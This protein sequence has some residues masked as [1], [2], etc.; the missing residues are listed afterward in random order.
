FDDIIVVSFVDEGA[1][2]T[3]DP[4]L[5]RQAILA[6]AI[7]A[8]VFLGL[9]VVLR[10][11]V[12]WLR[13]AIATAMLPAL[14]FY[15]AH[16]AGIAHDEL[17]RTAMELTIAFLSIMGL[18]GATAVPLRIF[19]YHLLRRKVR[20][21][22]P[23]PVPQANGLVNRWAVEFTLFLIVAPLFGLLTVAFPVPW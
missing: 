22:A 19:G 5:V 1:T 23:T 7:V 6:S 18:V 12:V 8:A 9:W 4:Q 17:A 21:A 11:G 13:L 15:L 14:G 10:P 2:P 16:V 3:L 20:S